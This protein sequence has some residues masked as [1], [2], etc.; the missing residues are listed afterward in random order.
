MNERSDAKDI[1]FEA[2][3]QS[4]AIRDYVFPLCVAGG[5][6]GD[7]WE[8]RHFLGTGFLIGSRGYALTAAHVIRDHLDSQIVAV[9]AHQRGGWWGSVVQT[10]CLHEQEDV[11]LMRLA[12]GP[13]QSFFRL[14]NTW[15]GSARNYQMW[16]YPEEVAMEL[17]EQDRV[18]HR[19]DLIYAQG[20][21][22]RRTSHEIPSIK[23]TQLFEL[24]EVVGQG[25]SG[26]PVY[27]NRGGIWDVIGIYVGEMLTERGTS[28]A[29]AVREDAFR[30]WQPSIIDR[31]VLEESKEVTPNV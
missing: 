16:G 6:P 26:S 1:G 30:H 7:R 20:Y 19:P 14:S 27:V 2:S 11:A 12:G 29:F 17:V 4:D 9:F 25:C 24:S 3:R 22:R 31:T 28:R 23:G 21:I 18:V 15:E 5:N 8:Y 13:W 10:H